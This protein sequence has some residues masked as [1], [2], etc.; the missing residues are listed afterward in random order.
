MDTLSSLL[1]L[2]TPNIA[3]IT[4]RGQVANSVGSFV[5]IRRR[6]STRLL[7]LASKA[8]EKVA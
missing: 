1:Q 7:I 4:P 6:F 3:Q 8:P 2:I 5:G